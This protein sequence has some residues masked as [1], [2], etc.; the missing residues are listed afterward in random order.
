MPISDVYVRDMRFDGAS[1]TGYI[2]PVKR[3]PNGE[4]IMSYIN[5]NTYDGEWVN[6]IQEGRGIMTY[7]NGDI[8][9]G[10]WVDGKKNGPD[11]IYIW[12]DGRTYTGPY[13]DDK[14]DGYGIYT[15]WTGYVS[16]YGWAGTYTGW[17]KDE[18]FDGKGVFE[19]DNGDKFEGYFSA[20]IFWNGTYTRS[21]GSSYTISNGKPAK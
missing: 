18:M 8:Y 21:D 16:T 11:G 3:I 2:D 5:G 20:N 12:A 4:G 17:Q 14:R 13:K 6:G 15:G 10:L 7:S 1:Y 19:F 9:D